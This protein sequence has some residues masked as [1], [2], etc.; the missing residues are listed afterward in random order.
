M[1]KLTTSDLVNLQNETSAVTTINNNFA[2]TETA[3]ENTLSRDGTTP[4]TM[5]ANLDMNGQN[6]TNLPAPAGPLEP[7]R[8]TDIT[9][10]ID[11]LS[12]TSTLLPAAVAGDINKIPR[13]AAA[14]LLGY[15]LVGIDTSGNL[16]P[17]TTDVGSLGTSAL[18]WSDLFLDSGAVIN[19]DSGDVTITHAANSLAVAGGNYTFTGNVTNTGTT[20]LVGATTLTTGGLTLTAGTATVAPVT[21]VSGTNLTTPTAGVIEYDGKVFYATPAAS[22]RA[23]NVA[24]YYACNAAN[25]TLLDQTTAQA[26]LTAAHDT[27]TLPANT[28][29]RLVGRFVIT[30]AA[31]TTSHTASF[32]FAT[33]GSISSALII[34]TISNP[35]G[36]VL[37]AGSRIYA[38]SNAATVLTAAN[39]SA[40]ENLVIEVNGTFR[41]TSA[42]TFIPQLSYSAAPGGAPTCLSGSYVEITPLGTDTATSVGNWS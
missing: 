34:Y 18:N 25:V 1:A 21:M 26:V 29:Y 2:L 36:N 32:G 41:M 19:F 17:Q 13:V 20:S 6:I 39:T 11:Q 40:T 30:R 12:G 7:L 28:L 23:V 15:S 5:S 8:L 33:S 10:Y 24:T 35:T 27:I 37:S 9:A 22:N 38:T 14:D 42:G 3:L 16:R 31:G 4:N